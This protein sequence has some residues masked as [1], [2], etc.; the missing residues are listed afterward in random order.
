MSPERQYAPILPSKRIYWIALSIRRRRD[1]ILPPGVFPAP[2]FPTPPL[3]P[4]QED[5]EKEDFDTL[6]KESEEEKDREEEGESDE[7]GPSVWFHVDDFDSKGEYRED[8]KGSDS[9]S[10]SLDKEEPKEQPSVTD[11][12]GRPAKFIGPEHRKH[13]Y[14]P[15]SQIQALILYEAGIAFHIIYALTN[16]PER[17]VQKIRQR[18]VERGYDPIVSKVILLK[19]VEDAL[20]SK[21]PLIAQSICDLIIEI[22][23]KNSTTRQY[24]TNRIATEVSDSLKTLKAVSSRTVYQVLKDAGY[25]SCKQTVKPGLT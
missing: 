21:R 1:P 15:G 9:G 6:D 7:E 10:E 2:I 16:I 23:I 8:Y 5:P 13:Y 20:R 12:K 24:S 11:S 17:T 18:A 3:E 19:Y 4:P 25:S 14:D 22:I